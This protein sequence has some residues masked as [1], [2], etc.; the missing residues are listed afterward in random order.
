MFKTLE[1]DVEVR[2]DLLA[3]SITEAA[4]YFGIG[5]KRLRQI[6]N[7]NYATSFVLEVGTHMRIKRRLF[8]EFL[9]NTTSI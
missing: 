3:L 2:S 1:Y 6:I 5:E 9:D 4:I 7:E 8:E